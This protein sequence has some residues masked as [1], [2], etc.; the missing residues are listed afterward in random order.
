MWL[1]VFHQLPHLNILDIRG[2]VVFQVTVKKP[3]EKSVRKTFQH[4]KHKDSLGGWRGGVGVQEVGSWMGE[5]LR[6]W[7]THCSMRGASKQE[8]GGEEGS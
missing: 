5:I 3:D 4:F 1:A 2:Q 7:F 8:E 6:S